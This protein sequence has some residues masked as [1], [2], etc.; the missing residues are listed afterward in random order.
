MVGGYN[1]T[2]EPGKTISNPVQHIRLYFLECAGKA[3]LRRGRFVFLH[4]VMNNIIQAPDRRQGALRIPLDVV[5][6]RLGGNIR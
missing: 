1:D 3:T 4:T 5:E 2:G 6:F